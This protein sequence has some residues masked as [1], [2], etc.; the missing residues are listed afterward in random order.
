MAV[1]RGHLYAVRDTS[2][3]IPAIA[4]LLL[5][6]PPP[7]LAPGYPPSVIVNAVTADGVYSIVWLPAEPSGDALTVEATVYAIRH[8]VNW[9]FP[10][11][12]H[13]RLEGAVPR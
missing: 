11:L 4:L 6:N 3:L 7:K 2:E 10:R 13:D 9:R 8:L 12:T 1:L 5:D